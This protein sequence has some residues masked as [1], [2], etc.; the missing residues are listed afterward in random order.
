M[1]TEDAFEAGAEIDALNRATSHPDTTAKGPDA[2]TTVHGLMDT[3]N[4][5]QREQE[6]LLGRRGTASS[7]VSA[8]H[9]DMK[10]SWTGDQDFAGQPWWNK[11]SVSTTSVV[12]LYII[13]SF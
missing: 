1:E 4:H 2:F 5:E 10:P 8:D 7:E 6:P 12:I 11:P 3:S 13:F 9:D